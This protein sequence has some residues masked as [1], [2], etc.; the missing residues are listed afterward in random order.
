MMLQDNLQQ[1][2]IILITIPTLAPTLTKLFLCLSFLRTYFPYFLSLLQT[3]QISNL[4]EV[5]FLTQ[6]SL[7]PPRLQVSIPTLPNHTQS[8]MPKFTFFCRI[9]VYMCLY[10]AIQTFTDL[11]QFLHNIIYLQLYLL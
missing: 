2:I 5:L 8:Q 4:K 1:F 10:K 11:L 7:Q 6:S 3:S 9:Y